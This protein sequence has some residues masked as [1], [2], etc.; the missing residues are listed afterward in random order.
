M[1]A[2][3]EAWSL[4]AEQLVDEAAN[5][6]VEELRA[7]ARTTR[8]RLDPDGAERR[9]RER[10]EAR[11]Y[12]MWT[13]AEGRQHGTFVF[14]DEGGLWVRSIF[15]SALRP[16]RGGPRFVD[17]EEKAEAQVLV[18]DPRTND[19][20]AYDL[21]LDLLRT[22]A[23]ADAQTVF[24]ARQPGV[25]IVHVVRDESA[26][27]DDFAGGRT[28]TED[29]LT[30]LPTAVA[31]QRAC[32]SG[33]RAITVDERGNPLNVGRMHRLFTP[34][35][36]IALA[37][38]DGGCRWKGCDR[39]PSY[40]EAHHIDDWS[41]G[42]RTDI[43]RGILLCRFHHMN[44]HHRGWRINRVDREEFVLR[45]PSGSSIALE[46]RAVLRYQFGRLGDVDPPP[47]RFRP[48]A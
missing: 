24:G 16:R 18:D 25:R 6:T 5:R 27:A 31:E 41:A 11:S 33:R 17:S 21:M 43:D 47:R 12:R 30:F 8:D 29:G 3:G 19:Q 42:G 44:L 10:Y 23:L 38:R 2:F 36:R 28:H 32:D 46:P 7:A 48:V 15:D 9:S 34:A 4:A 40:C 26:R 14:D 37:I 22:G 20:L 39:P 35:Q 13:D 1:A 45:D